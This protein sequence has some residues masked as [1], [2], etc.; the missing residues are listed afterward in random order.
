M[1]WV[2]ILVLIWVIGLVDIYEIVF[3]ECFI[4]ITVLHL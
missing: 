1:I 4:Y 3:L 2:M